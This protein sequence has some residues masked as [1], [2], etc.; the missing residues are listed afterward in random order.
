MALTAAGALMF[1]VVSVQ[2]QTSGAGS[3]ATVNSEGLTEVVV[4]GSRVIKNGNDSPTPVTVV[5]LQDMAD[6]KPSGTV[7]DQLNALP[8]FAGS[9]GPVTNPS[10]GSQ[11]NSSA[12]SN[13][14]A[15]TL[16]LRNMG[17]TRT[18]ILFD[19]HRVA[20]TGT[21]GTVDVDMI[22]QMLLQRVDIVTG[23]A[24]AVYGSDAVTGV[25]NFIPDTKFIGLKV[26][27]SSGI[28]HYRDDRTQEGGIAAGM[29]LFSGQG[30]IEASIETRKSA[31]VGHRSDRPFGQNRWNIENPSSGAFGPFYLYEHVNTTT[32]SFGGLITS[33]S[34]KNQEFL[35]P[36]ILTPFVIGAPVGD[37]THQSGGSG[38]Y[39][40]T[41][42][43]APLELAQLYT[44]LDYDFTDRVHGYAYV[45]G[46]YGHSWQQATFNALTTPNGSTAG[47]ISLS[48]TDAFLPSQ[49]QTILAAGGPT[50]K[51]ARN[52]ND[53]FPA[54]NVDTW[55][56]QYQADA[57]LNVKLGNG[58]EWDS[59]YSHA[60]NV[61]NTRQNANINTL[62]L[63]ATLNAV[64]DPVSKQIVCAVSL[65]ANAALYPGCVPFNPFGPNA[66][67]QQAINYVVGVTQFWAHTGMDDVTTSLTGAPFS[68]WAGPV[69]TAL[70]AEWRRL[71]YH[72]NQSSGPPN[73]QNNEISCAGL[74][75]Y[76]CTV[77]NS[78]QVWATQT[79]APRS[80]VSQ[81]VGEAAIEF[82]APLLK[83]VPGA[84]D[85][86]FNGAAR[87]T[88]YSNS[89][90]AWT[91]KAGLVWHLNDQ[92]T[93]RGTRSKDIRAP[94]LNDLYL[95]P[96][97]S[98][99]GGQDFWT[100]VQTISPQIPF[101]SR[102]NPVLVPEVGNTSTIGFV[103]QPLWLQGF[104]LSL[105]AFKID[106]TNAIQA[107]RGASNTVMIGCA[108]SGGTSALCQT[109]VRPI[110]CC[111]TSVANT[112]ILLYNEALNLADQW[113]EGGDLEANYTTRVYDHPLNL[114]LL[115]TFQPHIVYAAPGSAQFD[116]GGVAF[117]NGALQ[118]TPVWRASLLAR[119]SPF[120]N[121]TVDVQERWRSPLAWGP[122]Y[123][124]PS[125]LFFPMPDI[126]S[127]WY[128]NLNLSYLFEREGGSQ[129][130][131][132]ANVNNL[133]NRQPPP[134]SFFGNAAP[135]NFGGF[136]IGDDPV[137]AYYTVGF[138]YRR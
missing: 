33:G 131:V 119:Y 113:S 85:L 72:L 6:L 97:T 112:A 28:S 105:D 31:G 74:P 51:Y 41:T 96:S 16:N 116:M 18:L 121:F 114:R 34:L 43:E 2:A 138:R 49:Y 132:Y 106:I 117:A 1:A 65:T 26:Q 11:G 120:R 122:K 63:V 118:A 107:F 58:Y 124:P 62:K 59:F 15:N 111:N 53:A 7:A 67:S 24:S 5:P 137:G 64:V 78:A 84:K 135:G 133:F 108:S 66:E 104:S 40:D 42:L 136:A 68:T 56:R 127:V 93:L 115:A 77:T 32:S 55:E 128:T 101:I 20:P 110:D 12:A 57:G 103:Y 44:R 69:N 52:F 126:P 100:G 71:S 3:G 35:Q 134:A 23:G 73:D 89:G 98:T 130:E 82:D 39:D 109:V 21:D 46:N 38:T 91:W 79:S 92:L 19:G 25:V 129:I 123:A 50:F 102:G 87:W 30:H 70:S 80:L 27:G 29:N 47:S 99:Y 125:T 13:P 94:T 86:S 83:N 10:G 95:P 4:T 54:T 75:S 36:G 8:L 17:Y 22:P 76:D 45:A 37:G 61:Q 14:A 88:E 9:R 90:P 60:Q 81:S 48:S